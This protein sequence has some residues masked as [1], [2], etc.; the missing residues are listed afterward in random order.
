[1]TFLPKYSDGRKKVFEV[2][3]NYP[4]IRSR[5]AI[6]SEMNT[7]KKLNEYIDKYIKRITWH[8]YRMYRTRNAI[9]HSGEVPSNIKNLGEHL[10][11]Y[12]DST[13]SEFVV[14]LSGEI[15]FEST[16]NV[17]MDIKFAINN[18]ED[19][20]QKEKEIDENILN[21]LLHPELGYEM[22]CDEHVLED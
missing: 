12:V 11:S 6:I 1:M 21:V 20:L 8:L 2:L 3:A 10:H 15:P 19:I 4:V 9:I 18:I 16:N 17:M 5:I 7:T 13:L 22:Q 14:K